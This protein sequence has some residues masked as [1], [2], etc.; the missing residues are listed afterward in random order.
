M[1]I[2]IG[3]LVPEFPSTNH[4]CFWR[5]AY[6][7]RRAG[8]HVE[9]FSTR[10]PEPG[11][12]RHLFG[13]EARR[14]TTYLN[15]VRP[16][17][18]AWLLFRP[19]GLL[20]AM[21]YLTGLGE[22]SIQERLRCL[23]L[24]PAAAELGRKAKEQGLSQ[25]HIHSC[26]KA[27]HLGALA[28]RLCGL[29]YSLTLHDD[30]PVNG[31]DH[32]S[33]TDAA[34]WVSAAARSLREQL[35]EHTS[36]RPDQ[37]PV[38]AMGVDTESFASRKK[39]ASS[40]GPVQIVTVARLIPENGHHDALIALDRLAKTGALFHYTIA[41]DGP[42]RQALEARV[43][44]LGLQNAVTFTGN[45]GEDAVHRLFDRADVFL[46]TR[47]GMGDAA[48]VAVMEAMSRGLPVVCSLVGGMRDVIDHRN[49]GFLTPQCDPEAVAETLAGLIDDPVLRKRIGA[50]ARRTAKTRFDLR[51]TARRFLGQFNLPEVI[52]PQP[53]AETCALAA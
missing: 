8:A 45:L 43:Q 4:A 37:V 14:Q 39:I 44:E 52:L 20:R 22:S 28:H 30:L 5:E 16:G 15:R 23:P 11:S 47:Q 24:I 48:P 7:L 36:L 9:L 21:A 13:E 35:L 25:V 53:E 42:E 41:G 29:R 10:P 51:L 34:V 26:D 40:S 17:T 33:K 18:V 32:V 38:T 50:S 46:L 19:V 12:C 27:A 3:Y 49:N 2:R 31:K 6:A 1:K